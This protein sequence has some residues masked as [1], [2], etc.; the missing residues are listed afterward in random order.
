MPRRDELRACA[1]TCGRSSSTRNAALPR[2]PGVAG[3]RRHRP[4]DRGDRG[5]HPR[6]H[7]GAEQ[8]ASPRARL[9]A[10]SPFNSAASARRAG[11]AFF[12]SSSKH[13]ACLCAALRKADNRRM[14]LGVTHTAL[15]A[16]A[17]LAVPVVFTGACSATGNR[18]TFDQGGAGGTGSGAGNSGSGGN[19]GIELVGSGGAAAGSLVIQRPATEAAAGKTYIGCDF[20]PTVVANNVWSIF[21]FAV[22]VANAGDRAADVTVDAQRQPGRDRDGAAERPRRRSTCRGCPSSRGPTPTAAGQPTPLSSDRRART[23]APTT[24]SST[25]P[26]T[27]YQFNAL[28]YAGA[29]RPARARTGRPAPAACVA[30]RRRIGCFSFSND[31]SL[32]LPST[33]MTGNYRITGQAGWPVRARASGAYFAITGHARTART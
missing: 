8:G 32:L 19:G 33:A 25:R 26:V 27:V 16:L 7:Q 14:K 18:N 22:V 21:D 10:A 24:S 4:R 13:R 15:V 6:E 28:E 1:S 5:D 31:A 3:H 30:A 11:G 17:V 20:W 29:G 12:S 2:A 23:A 9:I